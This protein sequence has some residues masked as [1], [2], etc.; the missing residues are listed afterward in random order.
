MKPAAMA[1]VCIVLTQLTLVACRSSFSA[2][3]GRN[4]TAPRTMKP[5]HAPTIVAPLASSNA[6]TVIVAPEV[7]QGDAGLPP[8]TPACKTRGALPSAPRLVYAA[9]R[10]IE[11]LPSAGSVWERAILDSIWNWTV[12]EASGLPAVSEDGHSVLLMADARPTTA[13][14]HFDIRI[15]ERD[16]E[17]TKPDRVTTLI[18]SEELNAAVPDWPEGKVGD[19]D[20]ERAAFESAKSRF[21]ALQKKVRERIERAQILLAAQR[22][23]PMPWCKNNGTPDGEDTLRVDD[24]VISLSSPTGKNGPMLRV[25]LDAGPVLLD[26]SDRAL[27][28]PASNGKWGRCR[29]VPRL[30][31]VAADAAR[32]VVVVVVDQIG[33][34]DLCDA[35]PIVQAYGLESATR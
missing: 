1:I 5:G 30:S 15:V 26:R 8:E 11:Q 10:I 2:P 34:N 35:A 27:A 20:N 17:R 3:G 33:P 32:R 18:A 7:T 13:P 6:D 24:L 28:A 22:W 21:D 14:P 23:V 12:I 19:P 16:V 9:P 25:K 4:Q 29:Y 31:T